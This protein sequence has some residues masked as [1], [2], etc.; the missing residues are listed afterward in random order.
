VA[1]RQ[2]AGSKPRA[3]SFSTDPVPHQLGVIEQ[4]ATRVSVAEGSVFA[5]QRETGGRFFV[6]LSG[7]ARRELNGREI[8][9][10]GPGGFFG[11]LGSHNP[12]CGVVTVVASTPMELLVFTP[13][14]FNASVRASG[15]VVYRA[16][17]ELVARVRAANAA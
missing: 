13:V 2:R 15:A 8:D 16:L 9:S 1:M 4:L 11:E 7:T 12:V 10:V 6:V 5:R 17:G 3:Q 14:E